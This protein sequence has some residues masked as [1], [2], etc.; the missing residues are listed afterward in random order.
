MADARKAAIILLQTVAE[1][2]K[3]AGEIPS[4]H[5]YA[6]LMGF[7]DLDTYNLVIESL[8]RAKL[9]TVDKH[10]IKWAKEAN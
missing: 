3:E 10:L 1:C 9:I 8:Q 6:M 5:L 4:G 2:I 7:I